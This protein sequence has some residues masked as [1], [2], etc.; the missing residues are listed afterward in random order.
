MDTYQKMFTECV[1]ERWKPI[2]KEY[3]NIFNEL[4]K[5][6]AEDRLGSTNLSYKTTKDDNGNLVYLTAD[7]DSPS[8]SDYIYNTLV[9]TIDQLD[10]ILNQNDLKINENDLFDKMV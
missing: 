2:I 1:K 8:Q 7:E 9:K 3:L 4:N 5:L 6:K 10:L